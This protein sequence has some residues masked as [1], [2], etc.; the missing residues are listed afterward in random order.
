MTWCTRV[1]STGVCDLLDLDLYLD[2]CRCQSL[3]GECD[4]YLLCLSRDVV[5][6]LLAEEDLYLDSDHLRD[7]LGV[8]L[9]EQIGVTS[10]V[11]SLFG[12]GV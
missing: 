2:L 3:D 1:V 12:D 7:L 10:F 9:G 6:C 5:Q 4:L 11:L 8:P